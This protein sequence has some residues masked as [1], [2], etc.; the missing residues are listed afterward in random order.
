MALFTQAYS[1]NIY[2]LSIFLRNLLGLF[3]VHYQNKGIHQA[4]ERDKSKKKGHMTEKK[5][6]HEDDMKGAKVDG[7]AVDLQR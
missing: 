1:P 3:C 4:R 7:Y 5:R 2:L 6:H